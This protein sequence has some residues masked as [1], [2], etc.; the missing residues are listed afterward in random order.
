MTGV[1]GPP[2]PPAPNWPPCCRCPTAPTSSRPARPPQVTPDVV[3]LVSSADGG[4]VAVPLT[5]G[6]GDV[7]PLTALA[8]V[9]RRTVVVGTLHGH[10]LQV[11]QPEVMP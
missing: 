9:D 7:G 8:A 4:A 6:G 11:G 5:S 2:V 10:L 1:L 3:T